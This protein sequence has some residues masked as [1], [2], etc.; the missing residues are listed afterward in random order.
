[1][2]GWTLTDGHGNGY[3]VP[4]VRRVPGSVIRISTRS[5]TNTP[6]FLYWNQDSP[7]W[8]LDESATLSNAAGV[9]QSIFT[10]GQDVEIIDFDATATP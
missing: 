9:P 8:E 1:M 2:L 10:V 4:D 3:P 6:G 7:V 5:G